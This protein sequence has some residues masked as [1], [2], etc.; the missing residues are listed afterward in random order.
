M[1]Q[2]NKMLQMGDRELGIE[3]KENAPQLLKIHFC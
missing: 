2:G 3:N 1:R